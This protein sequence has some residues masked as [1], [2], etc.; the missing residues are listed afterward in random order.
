MSTTTGEWIQTFT[1]RHVDPF[2]LNPREIVVE[3]IAHAL[4]HIARFGGHAARFYSVGQHSLLVAASCPP[5]HRRWG[6]LH[7][8]AEA[9]LGDVPR[10]IK[11]RLPGYQELEDQVLQ[12]IA[13]RFDLPWPLPEIVKQ[14]DTAALRLEAEELMGNTGDWV[15]LALPTPPLDPQASQAYLNLTPPEAEREFLARFGALTTT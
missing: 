2:N 12:V 1:G 13:A 6:L 9:Y 8:A 3:D 7:D 15:D 4:S 11:R 10:P 5:A 14:Y